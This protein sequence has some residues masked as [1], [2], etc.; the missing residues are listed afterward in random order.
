MKTK[1]IFFLLIVV[2]L[3]ACKNDQDTTLPV[4]ESVKVNGVVAD[5]HELEG[6]ST[7]AVAISC[8]D[9]EALNQVKVNVHSAADGHSHESTSEEEA[10]INVGLWALTK[11]LNVEGKS[12]V[13]NLNITIPDSIAG[14]WHLEI[15]LLDES[16]NEAEEYVTTLHINNSNLPVITPMFNP[17]PNT[18]G[19]V[20]MANNT[21][22][23]LSC[24]VTDGDGVGAV[25]LTILNE[26]E[27]VTIWSEER[28]GG[29]VTS[30]D[31]S[32]Q[33]AVLT[34]GHY[35]FRI[36]AEDGDGYMNITEQH[37]EVE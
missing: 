30:Y 31:F 11:I 24:N 20:I 13:A 26:S 19:D 7:I 18:D 32:T 22:I 6:N 14:V 4:L 35:I 9:N 37:V 23:G 25:V 28:D 12:D 3:S 27:T 17:A 15:L 34:T 2:L 36:E 33:S 10:V 5:E 16:G 8:S 29:L 21:A 1:L